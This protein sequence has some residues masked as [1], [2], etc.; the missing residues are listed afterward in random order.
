VF[1]SIHLLN[2]E[3][4]QQY[5]SYKYKRILVVCSMNSY[6]AALVTI[7]TGLKFITTQIE[8]WIRLEKWNM[9]TVYDL[10]PP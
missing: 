1:N 10:I 7:R 5:G 2:F 4:T 8:F 3:I 9:S 6:A